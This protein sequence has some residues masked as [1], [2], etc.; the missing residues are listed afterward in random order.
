MNPTLAVPINQTDCYMTFI[1]SVI[2]KQGVAMV[3]DSF[4]TTVEQT[5]DRDDFIAHL[6]TKKTLPE[7][8]SLK[9]MFS[10]FERK[11]SYTRNYMEKLFQFGKWSAVSTT[12]HAY[13]NGR[14][15][16]RHSSRNTGKVRCRFRLV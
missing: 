2:A 5:L 1:A 3:S 6:K 9:E 14:L 12:G 11:P 7:T 16:K 10:L 13:I 15:G 4:V 8:I